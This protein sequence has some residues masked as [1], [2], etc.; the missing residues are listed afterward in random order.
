MF[1]SKLNPDQIWLDYSVGKQTQQ[2]LS[3]KYN[4]SPRTIRRYLEKAAKS[5]LTL[6]KNKYL[7]P[8]H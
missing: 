5:T 6:P 3:I 2:Q 8:H 7:N 4:C 1:K